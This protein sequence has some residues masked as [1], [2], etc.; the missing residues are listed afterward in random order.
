MAKT[1]FNRQ[2]TLTLINHDPVLTEVYK[3]YCKLYCDPKK[4][5]DQD[6]IDKAIRRI[7]DERI[8]EDD[9]GLYDKDWEKAKPKEYEYEKVPQ[10]DELTTT[11]QKLMNVHAW[12][13][14]ML[15]FVRLAEVKKAEFHNCG[16]PSQVEK[17]NKIGIAMR[18]LAS[19]EVMT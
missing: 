15:G 13:G 3:G 1:E 10:Y 7:F 4:S 5:F 6:G 16:M 19:P 12:R 2:Q 14:L 18:K 8:A 11:L 17:W 9:L